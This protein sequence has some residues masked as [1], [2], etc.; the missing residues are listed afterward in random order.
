MTTPN[1]F[2]ARSPTWSRTAAPTA[3]P[4]RARWSMTSRSSRCLRIRRA[5]KFTQLLSTGPLSSGARD[6]GGVRRDQERDADGFL[7]F[8]PWPLIT[9]PVTAAIA[10]LLEIEHVS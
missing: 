1:F 10:L 8:D 6:R 5:V 3:N 9:P 2:S 7:E 4:M